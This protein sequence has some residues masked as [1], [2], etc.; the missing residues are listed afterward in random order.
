VINSYH[1]YLPGPILP[2][3]QCFIFYYCIQKL[4]SFKIISSIENQ[5][6]DLKWGNLNEF[7]VDISDILESELILP[8]NYSEVWNYKDHQFTTEKS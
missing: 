6:D 7:D 8:C 2:D 3:C 1:L 5:E 4:T